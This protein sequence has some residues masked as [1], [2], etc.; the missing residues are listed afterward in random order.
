[1]ARAASTRAASAKPAV[2]AENKEN[3]A[4]GTAGT[5]P[6]RAKTTE[7]APVKGAVVNGTAEEAPPKRNSR[8]VPI[9]APRVDEPSAASRARTKKTAT[10]APEPAKKMAKRKKEES[11]IEE[12]EE[13]APE[14]KKAKVARAVAAPKATKAA[15]KPAKAAV[16]PSKPVP[17]GPRRVR[18]KKNEINAVRYTEPLKVFLFGEGSSGELGFGATRK[19]IDVKRPRYNEALSN[20]NVVR[21]AAGGMHVVALTKDNRILT[22]GV[23]DNGALGRDTSGGAV[24]LRDVDADDASDS[25][26]E[27]GGLNDVEA[28]PTAISAEY[29][30]ED[31]VFVDVAAGDSC[32]FA[33]TT[34]GAVY[35]WGTFRKNEGILGFEKG[36]HTARF[37]V[38]IDGVTKVT[39]IACGT[40]HVLALDKDKHVYAWGNGQQ[41]Q[42]GRR[43]TERTLIESLQPNRVGFHD[44][45]AKRPSQKIVH[46]ACGDYHAFA[47]ADDGHVWGWGV[48]NYCE[49]GVPD[50]AGEDDASVLTP[51]IVHS[52]DDKQVTAIS[53]GA[54]HNL[55]ITKSG[56]VLVWGRCDGAQAGMSMAPLAAECDDEKVLS[57]HGKPKILL[58]PTAIPSLSDVVMG[59][60]GPDHSIVVDKAGKAYSWGFS[61][62]YQTGQGT[63]DD[64]EEATVIANTAVRDVKL[65]WAGC[66]GQYSVLASRRE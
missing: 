33:L 18:G 43:V 25:E 51:R 17:R 29:F 21:L 34:E 36:N 38:Y 48:N 32:S 4:N 57:N 26:D 24:K 23:N 58:Q 39:D 41:N 56:Q 63:D 59:A 35:G 37:P 7:P 6:S 40:N 11:D 44:S 8:R 54:H 22:W 27:T 62:N 2:A 47:I 19:A 50:N 42:L 3:K 53:G 61:A 13:V 55:A 64:V 10:P 30:P 49:T 14:P 1:M 20:Q 28:T 12:E 65:E 5:R 46:V 16:D 60:C 9:T 66:G 31:T 52:L 15:A 45:S